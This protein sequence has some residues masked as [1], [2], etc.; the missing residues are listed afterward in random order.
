M[1]KLLAILVSATM[2]FALAA[3]SFA[4]DAAVTWEDYQQYL[5]DT[6][7]SNAPDLQEFIDQV[8]AIGSWDELDQTVSPWDQMFTTI[9]LSTW[10]EFEQGIVKEAAVPAGQNMGGGSPEGES[11]EGESPEGESPEGEAPAESADAPAPEGE[12]PAESAEAPAEGES[13]EGES[14]GDSAGADSKGDE[15]L[16]E[17]Q[18]EEDGSALEPIVTTSF[19]GTILAYPRYATY[20]NEDAAEAIVDDVAWH[21]GAVYSEAGE[22]NVTADITMD[23]TADGSDTNDFSG[24][25]AAVLAEG[26]G[27]V[28]NITD[29]NIETTGVAK[30]ALFTDGGA[31]SIV[32]N[33]TLTSNSGTIYEGY[34]STAD[35]AVMVAPPWVLGLG[36]PKC[37]A[38][39]TNIM[40]D[41]SVAAYIDSTFNAG[42]WGALSTDSGTNMHMVVVNTTV[43][44]EDSGYGAYTIGNSTEDYYGVTENV[45]TYANIMTGGVSTYQS[46]TGGQE[47]EV[48]QFNGEQ[49]EY[50]HGA[51]GDVVATVKSDAVA[52]GEVVNS[53]INSENFGFMCHANGADGMNI[54]NVLDGTEVNAQ[55]AIFL[56]KKINSIFNVDNA[57]LNSANGVLL[58]IIDNDDDY[59][60]L[61]METQWGTDDGY[62]HFYG[63]HMPNFNSTFHEAEGYANEFAVNETP[64]EDN[65]TSELNITNTTVAGDVWNAT[66]YVGSNPATT[67]TVNLGENADLTGVISAGAFSHTVKD[68]KVND[69]D[70]SEASALGHVTDI[71]NSNGKNIVN[72]ALAANAVWTVA[73]DSVIDA[74]TIEGDAQVVIPDGVTLT[75]GGE[76]YTG[77]T[78]TAAELAA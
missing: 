26:Q 76:E 1:K 22:W 20:V 71:V 41:Y 27:T 34:M 17:L 50:S 4:G 52:D 2:I 44:V 46:Y 58:Q 9:G 78:L 21:N 11:P 56:V 13:G 10:E 29:A 68:A 63:I 18:N 42:G 7:G 16:V 67:L 37:N 48:V 36:G 39:T 30:L 61:D 69:G 75:V 65:W 35:Q 66:G 12:A 8:T 60:G 33:S 28:V 57:V 40:G 31:V 53:V 38:R 77:A 3:T 59:V 47:I 5:I 51:G 25:G 73:G 45:S 55:D 24:L 32:K 49:D 19:A 23:T 62:G 6:A 72:V 15:Q 43:N 64:V 74:L 14:G 54:V 70:W